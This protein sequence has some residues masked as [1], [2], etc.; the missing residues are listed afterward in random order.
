MSYDQEIECYKAQAEFWGHES[1]DDN[2]DEHH[3]AEWVRSRPHYFA[4]LGECFELMFEAIRE[5]DG[6]AT[7]TFTFFHRA[8]WMSVM[9]LAYKH[10]L[11]M[12]TAYTALGYPSAEEEKQNDIPF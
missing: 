3:L 6:L 9:V 1:P 7:D 11:N 2:P 4:V 8:W 10:P 12:D 5:Q